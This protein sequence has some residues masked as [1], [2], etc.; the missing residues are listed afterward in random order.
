MSASR[1]AT[2]D[3]SGI[4]RPS[5]N[6]LIPT[7][8]SNVPSR[9]SRRISTR[10]TVSMSECRYRTLTPCSLRKSVRS[11]A[12][13]L[14]SVVTR[15]RS[16]SETLALIWPSK[17]STCVRA[18]NTSTK[19]STKPVGRTTCSTTLSACSFSYAA[20]VADTNTHWRI[21]TSNSSSLSGRLSNADGS[22]N[23]YCTRVS[24]RDRSPRYIPLS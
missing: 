7:S 14:V 24:L 5:R 2:S 13:R 18:G 4:S 20:G 1:I 19:G 3:T 23:P 17:S 16:P 22:R 10:S 11:S 15:T 21:R 9:K 6:R 8:T 12:M